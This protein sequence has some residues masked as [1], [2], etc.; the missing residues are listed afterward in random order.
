MFDKGFC[1]CRVP[2]GTLALIFRNTFPQDKTQV[3]SGQTATIWRKQDIRIC[4]SI[5][6]YIQLV[7]ADFEEVYKGYERES[8]CTM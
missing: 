8:I 3:G 2:V 1:I 6:T 7:K 4:I 5:Y